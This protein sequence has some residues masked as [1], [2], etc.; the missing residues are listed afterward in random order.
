MLRTNIIKMLFNSFY[1]AT[2]PTKN[3]VIARKELGNAVAHYNLQS[4][5]PFLNRVQF[6]SGNKHSF[7]QDFLL[8]DDFF[9][10]KQLN[11]SFLLENDQVSLL[12]NVNELQAG[13]KF[14]AMSYDSKEQGLTSTSNKK[15]FDIKLASTDSKIIISGLMQNAYG[16]TSEMSTFMVNHVLFT[17]S[18]QNTSIENYIAYYQNEP[19]AWGAIFFLI[20]HNP[21]HNIA[22][23]GGAA[24]IPKHRKEGA[25]KELI[26][27]RMLSA[28]KYNI[29][30]FLVQAQ[31]D[32]S[33]PIC[34]KL[35]FKDEE[36]IQTLY[37]SNR[38]L[39]N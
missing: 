7:H 3:G 31:E 5:D 30:K 19:I 34:A 16:F 8:V 4:S 10:S 6:Q 9:R 38:K 27:E 37:L 11:Y 26:R 12:P 1:L 14:R 29:H 33:A 17:K 2:F 18:T 22:Y 15:K 36:V 20:D 23:L 21:E 24:T 13:G 32:T 28:K 25:Y 35:G 39:I